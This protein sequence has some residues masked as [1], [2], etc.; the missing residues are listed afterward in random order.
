MLWHL[1]AIRP[2]LIGFSAALAAFL[3]PLPG[4]VD[5]QMRGKWLIAV[6][7]AAFIGLG[8]WYSA[9]ALEKEKDQMKGRLDTLH[10][11]LGTAI[12]GLPSEG[13]SH[14]F[15]KAAPRLKSLLHQR[16]FGSVLDLVQVLAN[17]DQDNGHV[18]YFAG[19]GHRVLQERTDMRG[20]FQHFL[21]GADHHPEAQDGDA[22]KCYERPSGYCAE[23]T[24]WIEHLMA[25]DYRKEALDLEG[26]KKTDALLT[27]LNYERHTLT[28]RP[29][30]FYRDQSVLSSYELMEGLAIQLRKLQLSTEEIDSLLKES[31]ARCDLIR[32]GSKGEQG[33]VR[34]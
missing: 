2:Y 25:D 23:R 24:E 6:I 10:E 15:L 12:T 14:L 4:I 1:S 33:S 9:D 34:P 29:C 32:K 21:Q 7:L 8:T 30:G 19:E 27:A 22:A 31:Q 28:S 5:P 17:A 3:G 13:Q 26:S 18:L 20:S 11:S 16:H